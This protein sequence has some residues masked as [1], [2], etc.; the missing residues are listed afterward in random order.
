M[1]AGEPAPAASSLA[2]STSQRVQSILEA[3]ESSAEAIRR[4][5]Q[6]EAESIRAEA[7]ADAGRAC[8]SIDAAVR[9]LEELHSELGAL[10]ASL[11]AGEGAAAPEPVAPAAPPEPASPIAP[12]APAAH[13]EDSAGV[14]LI[15][16]NMALDGTPREQTARFLAENFSLEDSE[17]LLDEVYASAGV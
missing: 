8:E 12:V 5:A 15:A 13:E 16:L 6:D 17:Q 14:R 10:I 4:E 7:R 9:R 11:R 3:A 1:T 2:A